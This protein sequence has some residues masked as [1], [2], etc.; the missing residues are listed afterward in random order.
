MHKHDTVVVVTVKEE[1]L[2]G[3]ARGGVGEGG[4]GFGGEGNGTEGV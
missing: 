1:R 2:A 4:D 3:G